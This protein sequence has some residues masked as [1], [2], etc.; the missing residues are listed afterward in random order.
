MLCITPLDV[1]YL[2]V[3]VSDVDRRHAQDVHEGRIIAAAT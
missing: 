3:S 2:L 1:Y